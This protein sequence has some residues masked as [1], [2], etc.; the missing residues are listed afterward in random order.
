MR[1]AGTLG[2]RLRVWNS[3][4]SMESLP[5]WS[6]ASTASR[7]PGGRFGACIRRTCARLLVCPGHSS[8]RPTW[9][10]ARDVASL[11][12][13]VIGSPRLERAR[14]QFAESVLF[15]WLTA[16]TDAHAKNFALVHA[17]GS[18]ALAPLYDLMSA[19]LVTD[20]QEAFYHGKLAMKLGGQYGIRRIGWREVEKAATDLAVDPGW[21]V[22]RAKEMREAIPAA[23]AEAIAEAEPVIDPLMRRRFVDGITGLVARLAQP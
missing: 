15:N 11:L 23:F 9:A 1:A 3:K 5:W 14:R 10:S 13:R 21:F 17:R 22:G 7:G 16:G 2:S 6:N 4:R 8:T 18:V 19:A 12:G 20:G